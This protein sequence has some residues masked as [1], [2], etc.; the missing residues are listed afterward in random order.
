MPRL[1]LGGDSSSPGGYLEEAWLGFCK[2]ETG[3]R[4]RCGTGSLGGEGA[5]PHL[6]RKFES[7][8]QKKRWRGSVALLRWR[9]HAQPRRP[10]AWC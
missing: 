10:P 4:A 8:D 9:S 2:R 3:L 1:R 5:A 7:P 6:S